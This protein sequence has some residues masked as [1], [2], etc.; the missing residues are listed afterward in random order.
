MLFSGEFYELFAVSASAITGFDIQRS[1][2]ITHQAV[3]PV[4]RDSH[5]IG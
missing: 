4:L 3:K 2:E 1:K 5:A